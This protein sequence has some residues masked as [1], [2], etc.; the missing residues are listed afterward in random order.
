M[1]GEATL[2]LLWFLRFFVL[3]LGE[4]SQFLN[5]LIHRLCGVCMVL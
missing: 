1:L 2:F 5:F 4:K 3:L